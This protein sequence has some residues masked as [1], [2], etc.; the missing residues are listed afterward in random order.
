MFDQA[1]GTPGGLS[2]PLPHS[3][4]SPME[5]DLERQPER[6]FG[7]LAGLVVPRPIALVTTIGSDDI[8]NAA[9]F[10]F[11]NVLG[12]EPPI[13]GFCP[14]DREDGTP[15]DTAR[16][17]RANHQF[18]V[19]LVEEAIAE[20]MN[21]CAAELPYGRS[22]LEAA[23]LRVEPSTAVRPPRI[24][25]APAALECIEWGTLQIGDNRLVIGRV[26]RVHLREDLWEPEKGRIRGEAYQAIG[27]MQGPDWYCRTRDRFRMPRP[28]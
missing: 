7:L 16:N 20:A 23:G 28:E 22:E 2:P 15:K 25:Q 13:V 10:S 3:I 11:F 6:A 4:L 5:V 27:R 12:S 18:V 26:L 24:A 14:G 21:R 17:I 9:P 8:V 19:N 1:D